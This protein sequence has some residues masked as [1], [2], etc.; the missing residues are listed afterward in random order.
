M[1]QEKTQPPFKTL[2]TQQQK[3]I[4]AAAIR[5]KIE[6]RARAGLIDFSQYIDPSQK[7]WYR[8]AH[9]RKIAAVLERVER[10]E[11]KRVI[12]S[13]APRHWKSSIA[14]V[15]FPLWYLGKH[16]EH[17]IIVASYALSLAEKYSKSIREGIQGNGR[18]KALY[19]DVRIRRDSNSASDWLLD[20]GY[21]TTL[22]AVGTGG[23]IAGYG[24]KLALLD[25]VS[26]PN[27]Q[28]SQTETESDWDWYKNVIRTRA[29]PD[30]AIVVIN[31]RVG[32]NDLV[33]YLLD[34]ERNDSADP[35]HVWEYIEIPA[36]D[37]AGEFIWVDRFGGEYY[38]SLQNDAHLW[39]VQYQ[40]QPTLA[41]GKEIKAEWFEYVERLPEGAREQVRVVDTAWTLKKTEKQDPDYTASIGS[42]KHEGWLYLVDP[43]EARLEMPA[44]VEWIRS[45]KKAA[46][47]VRFG[48]ARAAGEKI[49][50]QFLQLL[51]IPTEELEAES[52]DLRVRL[53]VFI[54]WARMGKVKLVGDKTKWARFMVQVTGFPDMKHDDLLAVCSG[55]TQMHHL[56][57]EQ[58]PIAQVEATQREM[59]H[60]LRGATDPNEGRWMGEFPPKV[61]G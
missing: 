20:T 30:A 4:I 50:T 42:C 60:T 15:K 6:N 18:Y 39:Q 41:E 31:N 44:T 29:E 10:G 12:I 13:I 35:P 37:A 55:L 7:R 28:S 3:H 38:Q 51:G 22:R 32:V 19:P 5:E 27:K 11:L 59:L 43:F 1:L 40:Q 33:G 23:G 14:S 46:P 2:P 61:G 54:W 56:R 8:A 9:L 57:I 21:Q 26:D 16:P 25:D 34:K 17:S 49:A 24:F 45:R 47:W 58:A 48:M 36:Q 53:S 52:V